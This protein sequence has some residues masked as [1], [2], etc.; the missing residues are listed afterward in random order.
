MDNEFSRFTNWMSAARNFINFYNLNTRFTKKKKTVSLRGC[1]NIHIID[2]GIMDLAI[3]KIQ[4]R[5]RQLVNTTADYRL[6]I[7]NTPNNFSPCH[8]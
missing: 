1:S 5:K 7:I 2:H 3:T 4:Q 8:S 6:S